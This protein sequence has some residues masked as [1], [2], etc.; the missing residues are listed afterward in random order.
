MLS[1]AS[2]KRRLTRQA[3]AD[4]EESLEAIEDLEDQIEE[5]AQD[6]NRERQEIQER[7]AEVAEALDGALQTVLLRPRKADVF[8]DAW[9]VAWLP[10]WELIYERQGA[11]RQLSLPAFEAGTGDAGSRP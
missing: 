6:L 3:K 11:Q 9:G 7:W 5:L 4:V 10:Y 2:R 8:V 1:A